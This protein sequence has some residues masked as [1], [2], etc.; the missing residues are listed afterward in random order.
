LDVR[1]KK[2]KKE[3]YAYNIPFDF[4]KSVQE[5]PAFPEGYMTMRVSFVVVVNLNKTVTAILER[6]LKS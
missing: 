1:S 5:A 6:C 4:S 2:A 3:Q